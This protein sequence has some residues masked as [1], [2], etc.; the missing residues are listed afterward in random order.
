M[1][2]SITTE[3]KYAPKPLINSNMTDDDEEFLKS[4]ET[5]KDITPPKASVELTYS[6]NNSHKNLLTLA[7]SSSTE[8]K[9]KNEP[10]DPHYTVN[11]IISTVSSS[12]ISSKYIFK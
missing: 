8:M 10:V 4:N 11:G 2:V 5:M 7:N 3:D 9:I 12:I 6:V 1:S